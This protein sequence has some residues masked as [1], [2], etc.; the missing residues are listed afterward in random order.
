MFIFYTLSIGLSVCMYVRLNV[1]VIIIRWYV[2]VNLTFGCTFVL[3]P[4]QS[5]Q[6]SSFHHHVENIS[7]FAD[8]A[9]LV[10]HTEDY[11]ELIIG[12]CF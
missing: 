5:L 11:M 7:G 3:Q 10:A 12:Y 1:C 9:E 6:P 2:C 8:D 4:P